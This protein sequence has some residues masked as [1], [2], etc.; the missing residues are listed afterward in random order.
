MADDLRFSLLGPVRAWRGAGELELGSPQQRLVLAVLLLAD[1][2]TVGNEQLMDAVWGEEQPRTAL[3]TL[4]TYISRLRGV[5][6]GGVV[7]SIGDGYALRGGERDLDELERLYGERRYAEALALWQ[8]EPLSGLDGLYAEAQRARLAE[9]R[10]TALEHRLDADL[11]EGRHGEVVSELNALCAE[12]PTRERLRALLMLALY[13][14]GRQAEA[15]GV[16][17]DTRELLADELGVDPSPELAGL[18]QR[19]ISADPALGHA[20]ARPVPAPAAAGYAPRQLPADTAD[21]TGRERE[22]EDM[23]AALR[24]GETAALVI[25]AVAGAGGVGKTTLAVHVAHRL[26]EEYPDGQLF[27]D[28]R[29]SSAHPMEP[30]VA[31]G[32]FLRALGM[33]EPPDELAERAALYRSVL[34]DRRVLVVL[35]NAAGTGQVRPL[36]PGSAA[37]G[38]L[39]TSRARL[40]GLSGAR[41]VD[42]EV[43]GPGVALQLLARIAGEE[44]VAAERGAAMDL[45]AACGFLPLAIR[46]AASRLAARPNWSVATL[47]DRL[48]DERRRLAELRAGDLAIEATFALGYE[49]LTAEHARAFRLLAVP[50]A[51]DLSLDVAAALLD[52]PQ[53]DAE[54]ICE[55]LVDVSMLESPSPGRY[56]FH[57]LL[58]I[59]ARSRRDDPGARQ[60]ALDRLLDFYLA[61]MGVA[62]DL[63]FPGDRRPGLVPTRSAGLR[64]A[65]VAG[66]VEWADK[67]EPGVLS[68]IEQAAGCPGTDLPQLV[69]LL[70]LG[71]EVLGY[72]SDP[73]RYEQLGDL[74]LTVTEQRGEKVLE[75]RARYLRGIT[76]VSRSALDG[77][78]ADAV[79]ARDLS[80]EHGD[81]GTYGDSLNML[82]LVAM[83]RRELAE[84]AD[85]YLQAVE[86][87]RSLGNRADLASGLGNMA[88][89]LSGLGRI[90]EALDAARE[91]ERI[92][93]ELC[94]GR[95]DPSAAYQFGIVLCQAGQH[96][97]SLVKL[98]AALAEYRRL[99]LRTW[100]GATL[101]RTAETYLAAG[102]PDRALD[103]AEDALAVLVEAG[104]EW[105]QGMALTAL[106]RAL[107]ELGQPGR[108]RACLREALD[109]FTRLGVPEEGDVRALLAAVPA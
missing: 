72:E 105:G 90:G 1:G 39:V 4:R 81:L 93:L 13:R 61:S 37:C 56:R 65:D 91:A 5:L 3:S 67:E 44:R 60:A 22:V 62:L 17:T 74:L 36:L 31:L 45:V 43:M 98:A 33:E 47:R 101:F 28:L 73:A 10:L 109:I 70:D 84:A 7:F 103:H 9:R 42:L 85:W 35:D 97:E 8:G 14:A 58:K 23:L 30:E 88:R 107:G 15:I 32:S 71:S 21:F 25:S 29:G 49:Q 106:G 102:I 34:A 27:V 57:D 108:S 50:D 51:A 46:I 87:W 78:H 19:I 6:G 2:R 80:L 52:L 55:A 100:E 96:S 94:D 11:D 75:A 92:M 95:Q 76:R 86:V 26:A 77:A 18:Y 68:C 63:V 64:F 69:A 40:I 48:S 41:Q 24:S 53:P 89:A 83:S 79:V 104:D 82:A 12:H 59:Y 99:R 16:Y 66:A 38:V 54:A 20:P